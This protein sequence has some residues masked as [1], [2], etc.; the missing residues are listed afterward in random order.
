MSDEQTLREMFERAGIVVEEGEG[1]EW[2]IPRAHH[3]ITVTAGCGPK[4]EGYSMFV[5]EF[6]FNEDGSLDR[7]GV[8]E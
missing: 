5:A 4:N 8:W 2:Q 7:I 3:Y 6:G 1:G